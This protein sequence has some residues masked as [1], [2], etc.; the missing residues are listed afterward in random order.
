MVWRRGKKQ[1][2]ETK[3]YELNY[4]E[5][6]MEMD[7]VF[8]RVSGFYSKDPIFNKVEEKHCEFLLKEYKQKDDKRID[9][10]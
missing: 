10:G 5:N 3:G 1:I 6:D 8:H 2:N 9:K 4:L 7:E